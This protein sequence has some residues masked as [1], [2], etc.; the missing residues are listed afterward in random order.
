MDDHYIAAAIENLC[1]KGTLAKSRKL[2]GGEGTPTLEVSQPSRKTRA[3]STS[4]EVL[5]RQEEKRQ[6]EKKRGVA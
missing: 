4:V 6:K 5:P 2:N 1:K 3:Y